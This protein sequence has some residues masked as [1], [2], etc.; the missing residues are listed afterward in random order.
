MKFTKM[1]G[2]GNDYQESPDVLLLKDKRRCEQGDAYRH[3]H[4]LPALEP[5]I[6][7]PA[8]PRQAGP[9]G[10]PHSQPTGQKGAHQPGNSSSQVPIGRSSRASFA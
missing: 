4:A 1:H 9:A 6:R 5:V 2:C 3:G 10:H 8:V 7:R